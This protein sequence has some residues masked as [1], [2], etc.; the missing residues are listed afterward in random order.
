[1]TYVKHHSQFVNFCQLDLTKNS[2]SA[3]LILKHLYYKKALKVTKTVH[4]STTE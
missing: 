1:M 2:N 3:I 4:K